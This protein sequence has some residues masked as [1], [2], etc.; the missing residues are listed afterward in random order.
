MNNSVSPGKIAQ[1]TAPSGGV[2]SGLGYLIGSL[3]VVATS[4]VSAGLPFEGAVVGVFDLVKLAGTAWTEGELIYWDNTAKNCTVVSTSN[5]R[6]GVAAR[7][8]GELSAAV[9]GRVR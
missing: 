6:I 5:T 7:L 9:V 1:F 2:V 8:G 3:F 4:T